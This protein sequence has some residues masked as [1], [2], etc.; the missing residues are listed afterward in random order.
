MVNIVIVQGHPDAD[1][2]RFC[3]VLGEAYRDGAIKAGHSVTLIDIAAVDF[4]CLR[5]KA[6]WQQQMAP[7]ELVHAQKL[8]RAADHLVFIFP[9][10]LGT[11]PALMK[12]F[13][14]QVFRP[15][16]ALAPSAHGLRG[17]RGGRSS[18]TI[19]TMGMPAL[20]YRFWF[21][22]HGVAAFRRSV[23][24]LVG[25]RPNK[26]TLIGSIETISERR[27]LGWIEH[28]RRLGARAK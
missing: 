4:D 8:I 7:G 6:D 18:R 21:L 12:G 11:L 10:W 3:R 26:L 2:A 9:L 16:F 5:S 24:Q 23:L 22:S 20:L 25:I 14:E 17:H 13:L 1:R 15:G 28:V 27:R 19:V